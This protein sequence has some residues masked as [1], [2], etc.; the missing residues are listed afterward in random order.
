MR[1]SSKSRAACFCCFFSDL[2]IWLNLYDDQI[3]CQCWCWQS[4]NTW[5]T[6][7]KSGA[8]NL[9][10]AGASNLQDNTW[11]SP[12]APLSPATA[13]SP[14]CRYYMPSFPAAHRNHQSPKAVFPGFRPCLFLS[15]MQISSFFRSN[16]LTSF[17]Y[18]FSISSCTAKQLHIMHKLLL[19]SLR[20]RNISVPHIDGGISKFS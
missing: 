18:E 6:K 17:S 3:A 4:A 12:D 14:L 5:H 20:G 10:G 1:F 15:D 9:H 7:L 8:S 13:D 2:L 11:G 16:P 19:I